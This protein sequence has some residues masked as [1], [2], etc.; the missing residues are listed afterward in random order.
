MSCEWYI[1]V[2]LWSSSEVTCTEMH[3]WLF[4][5]AFTSCRTV[6]LDTDD[7]EDGAERTPV[8]IICMLSPD[9]P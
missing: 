9:R 6:S 1:L 5:E 4:V 3:L 8:D 7:A 2:K